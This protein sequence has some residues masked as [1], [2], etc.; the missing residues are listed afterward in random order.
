MK[1]ASLI[2]DDTGAVSS[3]RVMSLVV[4]VPV[5]IVWT[6]LCIKQNTF[7]VPD[8]KVITL[9]ATALGSKALQSFSENFAPSPKPQ[10]PTS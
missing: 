8:A 7:I 4:V 5:M 10:P 3:M 1:L 6:V 2:Q 9:I